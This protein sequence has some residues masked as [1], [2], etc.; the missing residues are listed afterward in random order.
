[1]WFVQHV[2]QLKV[3]IWKQGFCSKN[4]EILGWFFLQFSKIV[5]LGMFSETG[6]TQQWQAFR[7]THLSCVAH[8]LFYNDIGHKR[9]VLVLLASNCETRSKWLQ[10][11]SHYKFIGFALTGNFQ[12]FTS[13]DQQV[14]ETQ[15][16]ISHTFWLLFCLIGSQKKNP[17]KMQHRES[18]WCVCMCSRQGREQFFLFRQ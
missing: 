18:A 2:D 4:S 1:M 16:A 6:C 15:L 11:F 7:T 14:S 5:S 12:Y 3:K 13:W 17:K 10:Y 8:H 9:W